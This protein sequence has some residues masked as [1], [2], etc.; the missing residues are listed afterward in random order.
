MPVV[1]VSWEYILEFW[2]L[3]ELLFRKINIGTGSL[4]PLAPITMHEMKVEATRLMD[5]GM[6]PYHPGKLV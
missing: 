3:N 6:S 2:Y 1:E 5:T 4:T